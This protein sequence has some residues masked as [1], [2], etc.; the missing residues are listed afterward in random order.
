M[1]MTYIYI[2]HMLTIDHQS[3]SM[4]HPPLGSFSDQ[5]ASGRIFAFLCPVAELD[6]PAT[7]A[8]ASTTHISGTTR[9]TN[10]Q[11]ALTDTLVVMGGVGGGGR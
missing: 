6:R 4:S 2:N 3:M 7:R 5:E 1:C 11:S 8:S 10:L 9:P